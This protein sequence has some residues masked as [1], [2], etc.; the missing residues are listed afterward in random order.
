MDR[1]DG[2]LVAFLPRHPFQGRDVNQLVALIGEN[3]PADFRMRHFRVRGE[4]RG[5]YLVC[6]SAQ[7]PLDVVSS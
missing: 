4:Y 2:H 7:E 1:V 6:S 5:L 3:A